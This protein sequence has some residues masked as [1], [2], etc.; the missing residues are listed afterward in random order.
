MSA[1]PF[2]Y[3]GSELELFAHAR[4]WK[5][6]WV[7]QI[8]PWIHGDVLEVGAGM[9]ANTPLLRGCS[10][11]GWA[12]LEPD[13]E[14]LARARASHA[15]AGLGAPCEYLCGTLET[16]DAGRRFDAI[17]YLDVLEHIEDDKGELARAAERLRPGGHR[18]VLAPAH[19]RL[20]TEFDRAVGHYRRY[21]A[22]SLAAVEPTGLA[23]ERLFYLDSAGLLASLANR[24]LLHQSQP[25]LSQIR[26]WDSLL[27]PC[28]RLLDPLLARRVGK[29]I[30][31]VWR[32]A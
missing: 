30:V 29:S 19:Q 3:Q 23:R 11:G 27:V 4:R 32:A 25:T 1:A 24:V 31:G 15:G 7:G 28:S 22:R 14:M 10:P 18:V 2:A 26:T 17:V 20:Y 21:D 16:L 12:C 5:A 8:R 6:Y 9:G 13:A